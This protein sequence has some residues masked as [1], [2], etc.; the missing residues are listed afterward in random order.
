[1]KNRLEII[2]CL[3]IL[4]PALAFGQPLQMR[5]QRLTY[6]DGLSDNKVNCIL[7]SREGYLWIGTPTGLNR[8]D[9]FRV[10]SFYNKPG[11]ATSLP[12]NSITN[13]T[14][15][16]EGMLW[17]ETGAGICVFNPTTDAV[18]NDMGGWMQK[19]G[20]NGIPSHVASDSKHNLWIVSS[21]GKLYYYD[22]RDNKAS[23]KCDVSPRLSWLTA[24]G[25]KAILTL[26]DGSILTIDSKDAY[27]SAKKWDKT[28]P[29]ITGYQKSAYRSYADSQ[30]GVWTWSQLGVFHLNLKTKRWKRLSGFVMSDIAEDFD[31]KFLI[32]TDHSGLVIADSD[33]NELQR[34]VNN[35]VDN[36][37][38]PD[39]TLQCVYVDNAGVV[40][41]GMYRMGLAHYYRGQNQFELLPLGDVCTMAQGHDGSLWLGTNDAGIRHYNFST[42]SLEAYGMGRNGLGTDVVVSSLVAR[43]GSLWFGSFQGGLVRLNG[44]KN[45]VY[46]KKVGGLSS[47]DVWSL[48]ELPDGRIV[49]GTLGGGLQILNPGTGKFVTYTTRNSQM[50][51]DY[52]SSVSVMKDGWL[53]LGHSRGVSL[54]HWHDGKFVNIGQNVDS[55]GDKLTNLSINQVF[56]DSRGL[57]WIAT[58]SGLNVYDVSAKH[59]YTV[60]LLGTRIHAEV[61]AVTEDK[62]GIIWISSGNELKSVSVRRDGKGLEFFS[63]TYGNI[64]GVQTRIFNKRSMLCLRD[65]RILAGGID[66]VNVVT[67]NKVRRRPGFG[68][69]VFSGISLLDHPVGVGDTING[70]VVL[71]AELNSVRELSLRHDENTFTVQ[72]ASSIPGLPEYPRFLYRLRGRGERWMLT[73][74]YEP[75]VQF[76]NL[77]PGHY[78]LEVRSVDGDGNALNDIATLKIT[79]RPP[80]YLSVWAWLIY[81]VVIVIAVW[82]AY[83]RMR[84]NQRDQ[85][86][87]LEL[88]KQKEVEEMKLVF[89]TNISHELRTPL[90]LIISPLE[91]LIEK[92]HDPEV[93]QKLRL[94]QRNAHRLRDMV[95]QMLD[96]RRLMRGK[97]S[98]QLSQGDLVSF[99]RGICD[100]FSELS[101]KGITL[102]FFTDIESLVMDF[103][104]DKVGKMV[105]NLLSN[106]YKFT[107][108][109]GRVNVSLS[110]NGTDL[111]PN[112]NRDVN[113]SVADTGV[114]ISDE[115]KRHIFERFYQSDFNRKAGG[116]GIGLN[117]V[118]EYARMHGGN[119]TVKDNSGGGTVFTVSLPVS[120]SIDATSLPSSTGKETEKTTNVD[121]SVSNHLSVT[122]FKSPI[123]TTSPTQVGAEK[124]VGTGP[125]SSVLLVDDNEDFLSFLASEL[126]PYYNIRTASNGQQALDSIS[127][128][129]P[130]LVLTD[131]MMPVMDGNELCRR[132]KADKNTKRIPVVMLT[133]RLSDEN[134][135]ESRECGA[136]DYVKKPFSMQLLRM[137][138]ERLIKPH[139]VDEKGKI[140]PR[141][142]Q[143]K[144]TSEDELF[145]DKATKYV[146]KH[147]DDTDLS[148]EQ[149][150]ED[151]GMSRVQL[152]R[153]LVTVT[154]K[155]P[156][157][158]IRLIRLRHAEQLLTQSQ[159]TISEIAY[160]VGFSSQRYFSKCFKE[161]Y[162][163]M[164]SQYKKG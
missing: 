74:V 93:I 158:F 48:A 3:L 123:A 122:S 36:L 140:E 144:I 153:R 26:D 126:T 66:G 38:L 5:F 119:V 139:Q 164:P 86:E 7:K 17:V 64:D 95:N 41:L 62:R 70:H 47:N 162:G 29:S 15:D 27:K 63:N 23:L 120:N 1:M 130:D 44:G 132:I 9:G 83:W 154:G 143:Q 69:V 37:S 124:V 32:A 149:M 151:I 156:S 75:Q 76:T 80:F 55:D 50:P 145:V 152:Y 102:T 96:L 18:N 71:K 25:C 28:I 6:S 92:A 72:L 16:A 87:K 20:M 125:V 12:D 127:K 117:L 61:N 113:I 79:V 2:Y 133:A 147:L 42:K 159:L 59:L 56:A 112:G 91:G 45:T 135:I 116:S 40:W 100:Q 118:W 134:E 81:I 131:V 105:T 142:V 98:L 49:I 88:K 43:D 136:D 94:I 148:V 110:L 160:K 150:A 107:P 57:L 53:A 101:D 73:S 99:V 22:F 146:E 77:S 67:P 54:F 78:T 157:E 35:P 52:I 21:T 106:A 31:H 68:N 19:H 129:R 82:Y 65:G 137:R 14:E 46:K 60:P 39:N 163:Y 138:I 103:D 30:G 58:G 33:G 114:G 13:I 155:T 24:R 121:N 128:S 111:T 51:S 115:D 104:S 141:I 90:T 85:V 8:Y 10:Q 109:G 34:I 84:Q 4:I 161:L 108:K 11:I 97:E 89:F